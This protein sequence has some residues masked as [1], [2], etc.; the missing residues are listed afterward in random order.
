M[1]NILVAEDDAMLGKVYVTK[2]PKEGYKVALASDGDEVVDMLAKM[3]PDL[4]LLDLMMP[5]KD[6]FELIRYIRDI[7]HMK[8]IPI[9]VTTNLSQPEDKE[10][11]MTLGA[12]EYIVKSNTPIFSIVEKIKK[13]I[14]D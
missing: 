8:N 9:L 12:T 3:T 10:K 1:K 4:I 6:G 2:L 14:G 7:D 13:Y 5:K 11:V